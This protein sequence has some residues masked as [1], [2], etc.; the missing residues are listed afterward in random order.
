MSL[1]LIMQREKFQE[2]FNSGL[3]D[4][5]GFNLQKEFDFDK[6]EVAGNRLD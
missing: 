6:Q 1:I 5:K 3:Q 4:S 2:N